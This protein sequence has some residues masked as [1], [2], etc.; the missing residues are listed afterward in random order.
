MHQE[1]RFDHRADAGG[2]AVKPSERRRFP[3]H[4]TIMRGRLFYTD[5][6]IECILLDVS[7][8]GVK[9]RADRTLPLGAPVTL[10]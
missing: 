6:R 10:K 7:I 4:T 2:H 3:R 8:N 5:R 9:L 1:A